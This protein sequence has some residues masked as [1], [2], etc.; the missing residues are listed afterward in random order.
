MQKR[1]AEYIGRFRAAVGESKVATAERPPKREKK[2]RVRRAAPKRVN[3]LPSGPHRLAVDKARP[4]IARCLFAGASLPA[5]KGRRGSNKH[6]AR[7][8]WGKQSG[9]WR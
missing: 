5:G 9:S 4:N 8:A 3:G 1:V 2:T 6:L 7:A